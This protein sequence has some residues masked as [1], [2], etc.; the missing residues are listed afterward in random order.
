MTGWHR[1]HARKAL[2]LAARPRIV[3]PRPPRE[4]RY[5]EQVI[6]ALRLCW[7]VLGAPAGKR[8]APV[9]P[10]LV[11]TLRRFGELDDQR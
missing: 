5:G 2:G 11:V 6:V 1:S 3:R 7:A 4:P 8:L 9:L 10:V